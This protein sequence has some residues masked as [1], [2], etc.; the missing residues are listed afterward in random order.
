[1]YSEEV[2]KLVKEFE[3]DLRMRRA[4]A[5]MTLQETAD[6]A[7]YS[8]DH[9]WKIETGR[10]CPSVDSAVAIAKLFNGFHGKK[11]G[12]YCFFVPEGN[13]DEFAASFDKDEHNTPDDEDLHDLNDTEHNLNVMEQAEDAIKVI[14]QLTASPITLRIDQKRATPCELRS[15]RNCS[16]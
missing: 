16:N 2:S 14:R 12:V 1:M 9:I 13:F 5:K 15:T 10:V 3:C 7:G 6:E 4:A 8:R 11:D